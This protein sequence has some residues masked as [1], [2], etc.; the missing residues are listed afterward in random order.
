M[1]TVSGDAGFT[2]KKAILETLSWI[3]LTWN[4]SIFPYI[5]S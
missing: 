3:A 5:L 2:Q 1:D 4:E